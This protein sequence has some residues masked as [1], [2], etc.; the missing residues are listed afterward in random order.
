LVAKPEGIRDDAV[1]VRAS[2]MAEDGGDEKASGS[3]P[4]VFISYASQDAAVAAALVEALAGIACWIAPRDVKAGALYADAIVRA[5][6]GAKV[7]V[8]VL[9]ENAIASSHV[10]K[11]I[12]RA[13]SKRRPI[14]ALRIDAAPLT[15]ALEYFLSES[16]WVEAQAG[17]TDA[18]YFKLIDAIREP[19]RAA[20]ES[21]VAV[22]PRTSADAASAANPR[23]RRN[24]ILL[25]VGLAVVATIAAL[26]ADKFWPAKRTT[27]EHPTSAAANVIGDKSIAVLPFTD[28]SEKK[29]QEYFADGMAEET[30]SQLAKIPGLKVIGRTSSF[31]FKGKADDLRTIGATLGAAYVLEGSVRRSGD[32]LRVTRQL[33]DTRDG[34]RRWSDTYDRSASDALAV[35]DQIASGL[36]RALQLEL[37]TRPRKSPRSPEAYDSYLRGLHAREAYN[38]AGF[39]EAAADFRRALQLDPDFVPA[40][41]ALARVLVDQAQWYF[42]PPKIGFERARAAAA[43][44]LKLDA[45]SAL[46]HVL[47]GS[48]NLWYDWDWPN[49]AREMRMGASFAPSD[50]TVLLFAAEE[51][52]AVGRW[53]EAGRLNLESLSVD[54]LQASVYE[55]LGWTFM[56]MGR[57]AEAESAFRRAMEIS[58]TY[59]G[60]H[61]DLGTVLLLQ[62]K[63]ESALREMEQETPLGGRSAGLAIA[64]HA[65]H[66][67][68]DADAELRKLESEH[69]GDMAMWIAEV[70]AFRGEK[71]IALSWLD[72]AYAQKDIF[73]W[74]IKGD[75]LFSNLG[76][77]PRFGA[78]LRKMN[79]PE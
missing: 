75:P 57:L 49:A 20:P 27:A 50:P 9:S 3:T 63:A 48:V 69:S 64:Y 26:L 74:L 51:P 12:E 43:A 60:I 7:F 36:A 56:R 59:A 44:A 40:A 31:Q 45:K 4:T 71:D 55:P 16:Q 23:S 19:A 39:E 15:P 42:V 5:I 78:F 8:L 73:L 41:E 34:A 62:G 6:S 32:R 38:Q 76:G 30:L 54:P 1:Q 24:W 17:N 14:I 46:A 35:Q 18:A 11:E 67:A 29:D 53:D 47:L 61:H 68:A 2:G 22:T 65:L 66:R 70:H 77:D 37:D 25:A 58:P 21:L 52:L 72:G 13:S 33:I 10:S 79:L 28:M